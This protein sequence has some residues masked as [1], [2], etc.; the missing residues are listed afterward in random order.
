ML[1]PTVSLCIVFLWLGI[2]VGA[3]LWKRP[4]RSAVYRFS[5]GQEV[6]ALYFY[7]WLAVLPLEQWPPGS[8]IV[9]V[10]RS[11]GSGITTVEIERLVT[12]V[13]PMAQR[14]AERGRKAMA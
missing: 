8:E 13:R 11:I 6:A 7:E 9:D 1:I 10:A 5:T 3:R 12:A 4:Q 14:A 2:A